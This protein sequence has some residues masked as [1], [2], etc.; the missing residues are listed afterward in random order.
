MATPDRQRKRNFDQ[1][2]TNLSHQTQGIQINIQTPN[3]KIQSVLVYK[4]RQQFNRYSIKIK[5]INLQYS[6]FI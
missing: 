2:H 4:S 5:W 3:G 6:H 1:G